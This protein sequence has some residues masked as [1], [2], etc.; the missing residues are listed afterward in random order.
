MHPSLEII[1]QHIG[2][3]RDLGKVLVFL[4]AKYIAEIGVFAGGNF[5]NMLQCQPDQAVA[6]DLWKSETNDVQ[7]PQALMDQFFQS[8][9]DLQTANPK[10]I[11]HRMDSKAAAN[12]YPDNH[13]DFVYIDADHTYQ[14]TKSDIAA[15]YPKV[16][17][18]GVLS[19]H[20]YKN[21]RIRRG[22]ICGVKPA[23]DEFVQTNRLELF[24][25]PERC[26]SWY[27]IKP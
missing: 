20:D 7:T 27:L 2:N 6:V 13:F 24:V 23:V 21:K 14:G 11:V 8:I 1:K 16:R 5:R 22:I 9:L 10:I 26:P 25:S 17:P 19:G 12:L 15:W 3:Y 18:Q 4:H